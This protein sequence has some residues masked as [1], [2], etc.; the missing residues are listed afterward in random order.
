MSENALPIA[1]SSDSQRTADSAPILT[2]EGVFYAV[3]LAVAA[4]LLLAD[5]GAVAPRLDEVNAMVAAY[6]GTETASPLL[7]WVQSFSFGVLGGTTFAARVVTALA[8]LALVMTPALFRGELGRTRALAL[9][10]LL[11]FTPP[12][13]IAGRSASPLIWS[14]LLG[15]L[16]LRAWLD[17]VASPSAGR[18]VRAVMLA[19]A[20]IFLS[21]PA[22]LVTLLLIG[23][24]AA[25]ALVFSSADAESES[26]G[27]NR[28]A[29][30]ITAARS[31]SW[32]TAGIASALM[33]AAVAT[34]FMTAPSGA[35]S[36]G[37]LLEGLGAYVTGSPVSTI[38]LSLFYQP[39]TWILAI[40]GLIVLRGIGW[41]GPDRFFT[42][43]LL[44]N[45]P[46]ALVAPDAHHTVL[47]A[48]TVAGLASGALAACLAPDRRQKLYADQEV[49]RGDE[50]ARLYAPA[51]G[52][53]ILTFVIFA[54]LFILSVHMQGAARE[55]LQIEG[56]SIEGLI[57]RMQ[58]GV[59]S[60]EFRVGLL[61]TVITALFLLIGFFLAASLWGNRVTLQGFGLGLTAMLL[62]SQLSAAW[63]VTSF[64]AYNPVEPWN[65]RTTGQPYEL[66]EKTVHDLTLRESQAF[67]LLP[68]TVIR[69]PAGSVAEDGL[70]GWLLRDFSHTVYVSSA[71]E[72]R[73]APIV[74][75]IVPA[76]RSADP[77]PELGGSY[78]GQRFALTMAWD[79]ASMQG[80]DTLP[81][82]LQR[83]VRVQPAASVYAMLWLRQDVFEGEPIEELVR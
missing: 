29:A 70:L 35:A 64:N 1:P 52:R 23:L 11:A 3:L 9:T 83:R 32:Q 43:A 36:I 47:I 10:L 57:D 60:A 2:L 74:I 14:A 4:L 67:P 51:A 59:A 58:T 80:L 28:F 81:W 13:I 31:V 50:L 19:A 26:A 27:R 24:S 55:F 41:S 39:L 48:V 72:A 44:L 21:G 63:Y 34:G 71:D 77:P 37:R 66:L 76:A 53:F 49:A 46:L 15:V 78:V 12:L 62:I 56:G 25:A 6:R 40:A 20:T 30:V 42:A 17:H 82:A 73:A 68:I 79:P 8:A 69:D 7:L 22:G 65:H 61:W 18:G 54:L 45:L 33:V 16:S 75:Q 5:L 38:S